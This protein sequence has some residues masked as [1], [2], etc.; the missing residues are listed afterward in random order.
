VAERLAV[1]QLA[2]VEGERPF[3]AAHATEPAAV[4]AGL[5]RPQG[6]GLLAEQH[7]Q[8]AFGD[9]G[10]GSAGDLLHGLEID[11]GARAGLAEGPAGDD[12]APLGREVTDGLKFV[13]GELV[14]RHSDSCL[15][16]TRMNRDAFLLPL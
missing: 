5:L 4:G 12:F 2:A 15:V 7:V 16:L 3:L 6:F 9:P 10:S 13:G 1:V 8:G 14:S 11:G